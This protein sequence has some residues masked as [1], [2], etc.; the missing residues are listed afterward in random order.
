MALVILDFILVFLYGFLSFM[1]IP[2]WDGWCYLICTFLWTFCAFA[3]LHLYRTS[4]RQNQTLKNIE[5]FSKKL[6]EKLN[7]D[8]KKYKDLDPK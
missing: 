6:D 1:S 2:H 3:N 7:D 8:I 4:K 5:T